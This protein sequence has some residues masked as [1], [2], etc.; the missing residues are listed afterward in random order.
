MT[1][2]LQVVQVRQQQVTLRLLQTKAVAYHSG[3]IIPG[4]LLPYAVQMYAVL[5]LFVVQ[6]VVSVQ[7]ALEHVH[8]GLADVIS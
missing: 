4:I 3:Q 8:R 6:T 1:Q 2:A 5:L 7:W